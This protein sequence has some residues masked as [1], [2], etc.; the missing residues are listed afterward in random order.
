MDKTPKSR[1][2]FRG[3][4][5]KN[6]SSF[7]GKSKN[8]LYLIIR[9]TFLKGLYSGIADSSIHIKEGIGSF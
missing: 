5:M 8:A 3:L 9:K 7:I 6:D 4:T 2:G 1:D